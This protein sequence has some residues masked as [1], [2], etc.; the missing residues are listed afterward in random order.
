M[1]HFQLLSVTSTLP[2][3]ET[4]ERLAFIPQDLMADGAAAITNAKDKVFPTTRRAMCYPHV[5][6]A[7]KKKAMHLGIMPGTELYKKLEEDYI[8][9]LKK[10]YNYCKWHARK[11]SLKLPA[12]SRF[13]FGR[14]MLACF[15]LQNTSK[16][17]GAHPQSTV[18]GTKGSANASRAAKMALNQSIDGSRP[19][20][21]GDF[22]KTFNSCLLDLWTQLTNGLKSLMTTFAKHQ[23]C[24]N[25][26]T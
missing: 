9:S 17:N 22:E 21:C 2:S 7:W 26:L 10:K 8:R 19:T 24:I 16:K 6:R 14:W 1:D 18:D 25:L 23:L 5:D 13:Y 3:G 4:N 11:R 12:K 15:P 20:I